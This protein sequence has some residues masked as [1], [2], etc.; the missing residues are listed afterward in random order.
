MMVDWDVGKGMEYDEAMQFKDGQLEV[1]PNLSAP[2]LIFEITPSRFG[3]TDWL[4]D[5]DK[6]VELRDIMNKWLDLTED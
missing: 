1:H 6:V 2:H 5:R 4:M 3:H